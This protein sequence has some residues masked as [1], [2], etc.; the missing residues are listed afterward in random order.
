MTSKIPST[1]YEEVKAESWNELLSAFHTGIKDPDTWVFRGMRNADWALQTSLDRALSA[2]GIAHEKANKVEG[3]L[4]RRF[5]REAQHYS[6]RQ[7]DQKSTLEWLA[8]MQHFGAPTRLLDWTHSFFI[9]VYFAIFDVTLEPKCADVVVWAL[10]W[11]WLEKEAPF[12]S[13]FESIYRNDLNWEIFDNFELLRSGSPAVLKANSFNL[14]ERV[15]IQQGTFLMP[16]DVTKT[17]EENFLASISLSSASEHIKRILI[18]ADARN[19]IL[20]GLHRMNIHHGTLFPGLD[21]FARSL[22]TRLVVPGLLKPH[23]WW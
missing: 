21:G 7:P 22:Q 13:T 9:A 5:Q 18:S 3:G 15:T 20:A 17:W 10:D 11:D 1:A 14:N 23:P 8:T 4:L 6:I 16:T 2:T 12:A 19:G